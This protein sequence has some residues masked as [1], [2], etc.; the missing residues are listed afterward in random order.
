[1]NKGFGQEIDAYSLTLHFSQ[2]L[3]R[4]IG[5]NRKLRSTELHG[6]LSTDS[7]IEQRMGYGAKLA[8]KRVAHQSDHS[9][10]LQ[11]SAF[12]DLDMSIQSVSK[13]CDPMEKEIQLT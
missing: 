12:V 9:L 3:S 2:Y 4:L 8:G 5:F 6:T 11:T 1:M 10:N 13:G 7:G